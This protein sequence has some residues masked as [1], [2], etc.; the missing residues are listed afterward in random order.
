MS[1]TTLLYYFALGI[2]IGAFLALFCWIVW[3]LITRGVRG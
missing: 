1:A 2:A 3:L